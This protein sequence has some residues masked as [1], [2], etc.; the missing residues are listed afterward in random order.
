MLEQAAMAALAQRP[1]ASPTSARF[2]GMHGSGSDSSGIDEAPSRV[3]CIFGSETGNSRRGLERMA[4]SWTAACDDESFTIEA[5]LE[6]N[7][8]A[9]DGLEALAKRCDV[10]VVA[11]SS[12]GQG[13]PPANL[14]QFL[15]MLI[16]GAAAGG[17]PLAGLQHAVIGYG[18]SIYPTFQNVPRLVDKLL[19]E[20]G[21]RRCV[22]RVELDEG[23]DGDEQDGVLGEPGSA[24]TREAPEEVPLPPRIPTHAC[25][26]AY[27][28]AHI[29]T[30]PRT[31]PH[32]H[33]CIQTYTY[34]YPP[35]TH[36]RT[37]RLTCTHIHVPT[38]MHTYVNAYVCIH[39][40]THAHTHTH[41]HTHM[42]MH[43]GPRCVGWCQS[44]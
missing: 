32:T 24:S 43:A 16:V 13:D 31:H 27:P 18:Q 22:R 42:H 12:F 21:S 36:S 25:L 23:P 37:R 2:G 19:G 33:T 9:S 38:Y 8:V 39:T 35:P 44:L 28:H 15:E 5:V 20:L 1:P 41:K 30:Y 3:L 7:A 26:H 40:R 34:T 6:G 11:T 14:A 4:R 29:T 17:T 10:L